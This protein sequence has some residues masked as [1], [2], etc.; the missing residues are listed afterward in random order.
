MYKLHLIL[1]YLLKRR[2]AWVSLAA[3]MLCTTMVLVVIS[4]MGGWLDMFKQSF[5]G[6][7]GDVIVKSESLAGFP[8]YQE[9]IDRIDKLP[10]VAAAAPTIETFGLFNIGSVPT[11]GVHVIG[12]PI[13][14][15]GQINRFPDS[16]FREHDLIEETLKEPDLSPAVRDH[17]EAQLKQPPSFD[18]LD[19]SRANLAALPADNPLN[20]LP[21]G[22]QAKIWFDDAAKQLV[23]KGI[24]TDEQRI[25][26]SGLSDDPGFKSAIDYLYR[27]SN[28]G[29]VI[30]YQSLVPNTRQDVTKWPGLIPGIGVI[31]IHRDKDG[32]WVSPLGP[33]VPS[34]DDPGLYGVPVKLTVL[35]IHPGETGVDINNKSERNYWMVDDSRTQIWQYD[36]N[37]VYVPF[38]RLQADLGM[39]VREAT[40]VVTGQ[41]I[42][43]PARTSEIHIRMRPGFTDDASLAAIEPQV[44]AIVQKVLKDKE[45]YEISDTSTPYVE[46]WLESQSVWINAIEN[47]K[48]LTVMLFSIISV[49]AIFLIFCIFYMIVVE[50]TRDIGIIKSVGATSGGV[51]GIFLGYGLAIGVIGALLGVLSSYLIV[52]NI[53]QLHQWLGSHLGIVIWNPEVYLFDKIP[54]T[55]RGVDLLVIPA[56]AVIASVLGA[57]VPAVRAARMNPVEAIRWE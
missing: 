8:Y 48:L 26:L 3:V 36:N 23:F 24:M 51:A 28:S 25:Q 11:A 38:A 6:L 41:K 19:K 22:L 33:R 34:R 52:H 50:K 30:D 32:N 5:H 2:I 46:T 40:D 43:L 56:I 21:K 1:K 17:L 35:G 45:G 49:V 39:G 7:T 10:G 44:E 14:Q 18:L 4:V 27:Y 16:L 53:N 15:I 47:E 12:L 57:L 9:M 37:S 42:T 54:N 55:M 29:E 31:Y 13:D 20:K